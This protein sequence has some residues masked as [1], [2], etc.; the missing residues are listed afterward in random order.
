M[1]PAGGDRYGLDLA[2]F[3]T[4]CGAVVSHGQPPSGRSRSSERAARLLVAAANVYPLT[5]PR[6]VPSSGCSTVPSANRTGATSPGSDYGLQCRCRDA[7]TG[8]PD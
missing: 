7:R 6:S 1:R 3:E 8:S 5:R 4:T 2:R